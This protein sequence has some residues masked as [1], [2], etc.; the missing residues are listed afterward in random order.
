MRL[1]FIYGP[2]AVGKTTVGSKLAELT[3]YRFFFNHLTVPAAKAIFPDHKDRSRNE[4]YWHLLQW[5]RLDCI[6]MAAKAELDTIFTVAYQGKIDDNFVDDIVK[7]VTSYG[8]EVLFVQLSAP[9]TVLTERVGNN[10]RSDLNLGKMTDPAHLKETLHPGMYESVKYP[11]IL[12]LDTSEL[13]PDSA[14]RQI[15]QHFQL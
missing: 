2:P 10:S 5:L 13:E 8:G 4:E 14:A 7:T 3:G 15:V 9:E 11:G 12:K 1:I 6:E